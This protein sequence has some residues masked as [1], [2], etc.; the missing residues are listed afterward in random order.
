MLSRAGMDMDTGI[1]TGM[2]M[3]TGT[4]TVDLRVTASRAAATAAVTASK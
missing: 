4:T 3:D 1:A 2:T